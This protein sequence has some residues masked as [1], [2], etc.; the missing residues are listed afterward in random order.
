MRRRPVR[1]F[2]LLELIVVMETQGTQIPE[3]VPNTVISFSGGVADCIREDVPWLRYRDLGPLLGQAIR[4][5]LLCQK[6]YRLGNETIQATVIGAG[7][8]SAQLSGSTVYCENVSLPLKN[9]PVVFLT[10]NEQALPH[11][12]L[13]QC[14]HQRLNRPDESCVLAFPGWEAPE[15]AQ[16]T[17]LADAL[18]EAVGNRP[19]YIVSEADMAKALGHALAL[20]LPP[21][22]PCLCLDR[23]HLEENS[24]LDV[25]LP[26]GP[27]IGV[28]IK[29]LIFS[30]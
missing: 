6:E 3:P 4:K 21:K 14:L 13:V 30:H 18:A 17:A 25:G 22:T 11:R 9:L 7:C 16:I 8:H 20:R 15:Y 12:E 24:Y 23:I 27:A 2:T 29:T 28:V 10:S 1:H 5:S 26:V 19:V